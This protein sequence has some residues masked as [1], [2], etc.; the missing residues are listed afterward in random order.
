MKLSIEK[1]VKNRGKKD[2]DTVGATEN[3]KQED[4][5][6]LSE[7]Q[8]NPQFPAL[9]SG[10][11]IV[12]GGAGRGR[13]AV[14]ARDIRVGE[15]VAVEQAAVGILDREQARTHC[16]HCL[17]ATQAPLP[18]PGCSGVQFCSSSC[19]TTALSSY[20]PHEC[21]HTDT[22]YK[23]GLGAWHL[24][25]RLLTAT[26][27]QAVQAGCFTPD[28]DA[29][30]EGVYLSSAPASFASLV[31][32]DGPGGGKQ[33]PEL[34]MQAHVVVF[35]LRLLRTT[36]YLPCDTDSPELSEEEQLAGTVLH[37]L[38][39][40]AYYNTHEITELVVTPGGSF[41][42]SRPRRIGRVTNPSLALINH[43]CDPNYR[44]VS[45][46]T[47]TLGF[48]CKPISKGKEISDVYSKPFSGADR[49]ERQKYLRKYNFQVKYF[50]EINNRN[51]VQC[52]CAACREDWSEA[53]ALPAQL[54]G[55]PPRAYFQVHLHPHLAI[56]S[57][58]L[59][60]FIF[61]LDGGWVASYIRIRK[62][63]STVT[64]S[65]AAE[66]D[67]RAAE[68]AAADRGQLRAAGAGRG[69]QGK[70][71]A[72]AGEADRALL[73]GGGAAQAGQAAAPADCVQGEHATPGTAN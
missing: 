37:H 32:H 14:A 39:R 24:A 61:V 28:P 56:Q 12:W 55:L 20:H 63:C 4:K 5:D 42:E 6:L 1:E 50:K 60:T 44:R 64:Y 53:G 43:S 16:W 36:G 68:A 45:N 59:L 17:T 66:S 49:A 10:V 22:L 9:S 72:A 65:A 38:M 47:T 3:G 58:G 35:F 23:A 11:R 2:N 30:R 46:G 73:S 27:W 52:E 29:G 71:S 13:Y 62:L 48:A 8:P 70:P 19:R 26:P 33:A 34:M 54:D 31:T 51:G 67:T 40:A 25:Y 41:R 21:G 69:Q 7:F 18:C 57:G 15:L